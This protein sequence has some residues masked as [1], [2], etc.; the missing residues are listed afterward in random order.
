MRGAT[1]YLWMFRQAYASTKHG[2]QGGVRG[3]DKPRIATDSLAGVRDHLLRMRLWTLG[4]R[5]YLA[6]LDSAFAE[7]LARTYPHL[8]PA[9]LL[10]CTRRL[11][12]FE[13]IA[14]ITSCG[15]MARPG[16]RVRRR[17]HH[18]RGR[19][20]LV[21]PQALAPVWYNSQR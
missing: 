18:R 4:A 5:G 13:A 6:R 2:A 12:A 21:R 7:R 1:L 16:A 19:G 15:S 17:R 3:F 11:A 9:E 8:E 14:S 10:D 20:T